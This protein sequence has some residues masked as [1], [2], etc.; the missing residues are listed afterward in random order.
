M[1]KFIYKFWYFFVLILAGI[2][3]GYMYWKNIGCNS[4]SCPI[5]S[6]WQSSLLIGGMLGYLSGSVI[7][8]IIRKKEG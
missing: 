1:R 5:T 4:G 3:G 2:T 7:Y 8:D 6:H